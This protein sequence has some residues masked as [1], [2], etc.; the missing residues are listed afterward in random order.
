MHV[1]TW[2]GSQ[3]N[4]LTFVGEIRETPGTE[5]FAV[6]YWQLGYRVEST[7]GDGRVDT[8]YSV[9]SVNKEFSPFQIFLVGILHVVFVSFQRGFTCNLSDEGRTETCLA[10]FHYRFSHFLVLGNQG[11]CTYTAFAIAFGDW[12]DE[13]DI[14]FNP[15]KMES[16]DVRRTSVDK[17]PIHFVGNQV[18]IML[19]DEV[20]NLVHFP[21]GI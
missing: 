12:V 10:E 4:C 8:W 14:F 19:L 11:S 9:D 6:I 1:E 15:F 5:F 16:R 21:A 18:Q 20:A 3:H 7:H 2:S 13:N 17:V